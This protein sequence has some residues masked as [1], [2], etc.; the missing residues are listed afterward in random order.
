M[1]Y[2]HLC[3]SSSLVEKTDHLKD[4]ACEKSLF[5]VVLT[6][7][8]G[9]DEEPNCPTIRPLKCF[10][11]NEMCWSVINLMDIHGTFVCILYT[12]C[13]SSLI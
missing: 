4:E 5:N 9:S 11:L 13:H 2:K 1:I 6:C 7:L 8:L 12:K 3:N 10:I